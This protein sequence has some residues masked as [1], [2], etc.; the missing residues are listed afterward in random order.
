MLRN[1]DDCGK[2]YDDLYRYTI[3][4]HDEF[5]GNDFAMAQVQARP[6]MRRLAEPVDEE[7]YLIQA[8]LGFG[9]LPPP[10]AG[11]LYGHLVRVSKTNRHGVTTL[12]IIHMTINGAEAAIA[13]EQQVPLLTQF[14]ESLRI[15][16][17]QVRHFGE[18][19]M[20]YH[21]NVLDFLHAV[22]WESTGLPFDEAVV[23]CYTLD[24]ALW[25]R[26]T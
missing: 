8:L 19:L 6:P 16:N 9:H 22:R 18:V 13:R 20:D 7:G 12:G 1:C 5:A 2:R 24:D 10:P 17:E 26:R 21:G 14:V 25:V 4:P 15:S 23:W 3:C 11:R